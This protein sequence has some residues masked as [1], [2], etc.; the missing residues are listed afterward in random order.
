MVTDILKEFYL[1]F[2]LWVIGFNSSSRSFQSVQEPV[3]MNSIIPST[4]FTNK[5]NRDQ[6]YMITIKYKFF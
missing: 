4:I 5:N 1:K 6:K 2:Y 3:M